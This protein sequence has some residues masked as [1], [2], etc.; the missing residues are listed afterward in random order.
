MCVCIND[1][2]TFKHCCRRRRLFVVPNHTLRS[3]KF[4][5]RWQFYVM[6]SILCFFS[7]FLFSKFVC[8]GRLLMRASLSI[9]WE[10][11]CVYFHKM[12]EKK[13]H[14]IFI[15]IIVKILMIMIIECVCYFCTVEGCVYVFAMV[16]VGMFCLFL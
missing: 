10:S 16:R 14:T 9:K 7:L 13:T 12:K 15:I 8:F 5:V 4:I 6:A 2:F 3:I 1:L 11:I